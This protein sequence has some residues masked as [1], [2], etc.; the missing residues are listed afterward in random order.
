MRHSFIHSFIIPAYSTRIVHRV[1]G[2][3]KFFFFFLILIVMYWEAR[4][5][6]HQQK[7][8]LDG[9]VLFN[10][11]YYRWIVRFKLNCGPSACRTVC[12][13]LHG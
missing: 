7:Q 9:L 5:R 12:G 2:L 10:K 6:I 11:P 8:A 4:M 3:S 1:T 13:E